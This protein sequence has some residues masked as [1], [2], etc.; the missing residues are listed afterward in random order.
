MPNYTLML[1][2]L[3]ELY[4]IFLVQK[5]YQ[6]ELKQL[7]HDVKVLEMV[8][9][10]LDWFW[11][12]NPG[13]QNETTLNITI[14]QLHERI[15]RVNTTYTKHTD[16]FKSRLQTFID[17]FQQD[18]TGSLPCETATNQLLIHAFTMSK[19]GI[20]EPVSLEDIALSELVTKEPYMRYIETKLRLYTDRTFLSHDPMPSDES[21]PLLPPALGIKKTKASHC[22]FALTSLKRP[23]DQDP[24]C[25]RN[26]YPRFIEDMS[27]LIT[28]PASPK[29]RDT[30]K[31]HSDLSTE[32][33]DNSYE[34]A[35]LQG[36]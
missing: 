26:T 12:I 20:L 17:L 24:Y 25:T 28:T 22:L 9:V 34:T 33:D 16:E 21:Q 8:A 13:I 3:S 1:E 35:V 14:I 30:K 6:K 32:I 7:N 27:T 4:D 10:R 23:N 31:I 15:A 5:Q 29:N 36:H 18:Y 11:P 19:K 2:H